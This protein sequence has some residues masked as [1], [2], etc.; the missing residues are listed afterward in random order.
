MSL[1][2]LFGHCEVS[3]DTEDGMC[4]TLSAAEL[5]T[6]SVNVLGDLEVERVNHRSGAGQSESCA[7]IPGTGMAF[8]INDHRV[9][10]DDGAEYGATFVDLTESA[11]ETPRSVNDADVTFPPLRLIG[12]GCYGEVACPTQRPRRWPR[13]GVR[14]EGHAEGNSFP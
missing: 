9:V 1:K 3:G 12:A 8:T 14:Q 11:T 7:E 2:W 4:L 10:A 6:E 5:A 13:R